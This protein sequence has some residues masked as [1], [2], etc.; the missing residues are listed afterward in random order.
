[1]NDAGPALL[2]F[3]SE[4][5]P[6]YY[7]R[8]REIRR[9]ATS[10]LS[11]IPATFPTYTRHTVDH[12]DEIISQLS[13]I[14]FAPD[15]DRPTLK[16]SAVEAYILVVT[17]LLHDAGMVAS[18]A[19]KVDIL[20]SP[21][22]NAWVQTPDAAAR[23]RAILEMREIPVDA[24]A[25]A[26]SDVSRFRSDVALRQ[27]IAEFIR[28]RH[29]SR[30]AMLVLGNDDLG[31]YA[32]FDDP[33]LRRTIADICAAHG[34]D[35]SELQDDERF[36]DRRDIG[37]DVVNVR[38][39][40]LLLR[41]G[42]LL[43]MRF[44]RAC[45][46]LVQAASPIPTESL[47]HWTQ[48]RSINSRLTAPD[49]IEIRAECTN[50]DED[51]ILRDWCRWIV[52]ETN[53]AGV[54]MH[55]AKRHGGWVPPMAS[56][57]GSSPT[58]V[59]KPSADASYEPV[60]WRFQLDESAVLDRLIA[61][62]YDQP[63]A[64][65]RELLQNALDATR[66]RAFETIRGAAE[67]PH[68]PSHL[69]EELRERLPV[70]VT[71]KWVTRSNELTGA[72]EERQVLTIEDNGCGMTRDVF[73]RYFLQV[74]R[75]FYQSDEFKRT[76][77]FTPTSRFGIGFLSVFAVSQRVTVET[78]TSA[79]G[80]T[81]IRATLTGAR[82]YL[83]IERCTRS[84]PGTRIE[85]LLADPIEYPELLRFLRDLCVRVEFP[86]EVVSA[87]GSATTIT[88]EQT[89]AFASEFENAE[90]PPRT[91]AVRSFPMNASGVE[92]DLYVLAVVDGKGRESWIEGDFALRQYPARFPTAR[93]VDFPGESIALH[94][95]QVSR[96]R[97]VSSS[98]PV[99]R[100]TRVDLRGAEFS[101]TLSRNELK[102]FPVVARSLTPQW[103]D[104]VRQHLTS[105]GFRDQEE[106][107][108]YLQRL[109]D[110]FPELP[111]WTDL[112]ETVRLRKG[113]T[114]L[115][116]SLA[117]FEHLDC[118]R[119]PQRGSDLNGQPTDEVPVLEYSA[120]SIL[121]SLFIKRLFVGRRPR[122][123][124]L[125]RSRLCVDWEIGPPVTFPEMHFPHAIVDVPGSA[126]AAFDIYKT[127]DSVY[128]TVVFNGTNELIQWLHAIQEASES[129][130]YGITR[131][132]VRNVMEL[133][134]QQARYGNRNDDLGVALSN[135]GA[136]SELPPELRPPNPSTWS[137]VR[138]EIVVAT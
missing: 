101:P 21:E 24:N 135:W 2:R 29:H 7:E 122:N 39:L 69:A 124:M 123:V 110:G 9:R 61:D 80:E 63:L 62:A 91:F 116:L 50:A 105:R 66:V 127:T 128:A 108:A 12:S 53:G 114:G 23:Y 77:A 67:L 64:F 54:M 51:R 27:L 37:D 121:S 78:L 3:L 35:R 4:S 87:A 13:R 1:M 42:D 59:I 31:M 93:Q 132:A 104:L 111:L 60:A 74:G 26:N 137:F 52:D 18:D 36:P 84:V 96:Y 130:S 109:M 83:L 58:I 136:A 28:T 99:A 138:P 113:S 41:L 133:I 118:I 25:G 20:Q 5:N 88:Q 22:W 56:L 134:Y 107:F 82:N 73:Q 76:A 32:S 95:L 129:G 85:I 70:V 120:R 38:F 15:S 81:A 72:E 6:R 131:R 79:G 125:D 68:S 117:E 10:W 48:Y 100:R 112:E 89:G 106:R 71:L 57:D 92:G 45:P 126:A 86:I 94:G 97:A 90:V 49:R 43:D 103:E 65:V 34:L 115:W 17:A 8:F 14:L 30:S 16:M 33:S 75:S 44:D 46:M 98:F 119:V 11:Y 19:E 102:R 55:G 47:P 40:A